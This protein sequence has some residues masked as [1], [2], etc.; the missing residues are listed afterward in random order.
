[1]KLVWR[2][3]IASLLAVFFLTTLAEA[4]VV[5]RVETHSKIKVSDR[6]VSA[7]ADVYFVGIL[8]SR[9]GRCVTDSVLKLFFDGVKIAAKSTDNDGKAYFRTRPQTTGDWQ[10][11][12]E[13]ERGGKHPHRYYCTPSRSKLVTVT[14]R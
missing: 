12:F 9:K 3:G 7:G 10:I 11:R 5:S 4:N 14:V 1:V 6:S 2:A 13:G 8:N